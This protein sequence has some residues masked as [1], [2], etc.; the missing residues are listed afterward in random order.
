SSLV[1]GV[2]FQEIDR[3]DDGIRTTTGTLSAQ[4]NQRFDERLRLS[5]LLQYQLTDD[6]VSIDSEAF[7]QQL[8]VSWRYRQTEVYAQIRTSIRNTD[9]DDTSF[10]RFIAGIRREF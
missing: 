3:E 4:W 9:A 8:D 1:F 10:Q 6:N 7:E 5:L 2:L